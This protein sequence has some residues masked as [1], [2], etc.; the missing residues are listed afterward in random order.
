MTAVPQSAGGNVFTGRGAR[1]RG[2]GGPVVVPRPIREPPSVGGQDYPPRLASTALQGLGHK[3]PHRPPRATCV[4]RPAP[5]SQPEERGA[6]PS[7]VTEVRCAPR[8]CARR[9]GRRSP[10]AGESPAQFALLPPRLAAGAG[11]ALKQGG[12]Q[13]GFSVNHRGRRPG[14]G[15]SR[16]RPRH[17]PPGGPA[18]A[19]SFRTAPS[20]P[21][22]PPLTPRAVTG[23]GSASLPDSARELSFP[24]IIKAGKLKTKKS[25]KASDFSD[26]ANWPTPSELVNTE[27]TFLQCQSVISLGNKKPQSRKEREDK[28]EKRSN[29]ESKE[30]RETKLDGP[31]ENVSE[32]EA[33]SSNQR[34]KANKHKWV[35][36]HLDD[37]RPD[38]QERPGSR[39]SS[40]CQ[41]E[42]NKSS[43]NNRRN[44]TRSWRHE[45]EKRD[46]QDEVSSVRSEG[47]NI[48]GT[49]RGRG[50]SRGRGRGRGRVNPRLNFDY[51][52]GY[53]EHGERTG[54]PFET[55]LN[56]SMMYYYDD[57]TGVQVYPVEEALLK[58]YIKRQIEYY[59]SIENL[60]RDFFLRRKMDEQGFL[61]I[62]LIAG[63]HRVRALTTNLNLILEALKDSTEVEIVDEKMRK[64]IEPEKWPIPGPP[65]RSVPQTDF[66][67]LIDCP[68][69]V[70]GQ[71]FGSHTESA[72]NSPR[73]GS[74]LSPKKN[75]E[76]SNLQAMS[77]DLSA[78]L[79]DLDSEPWIEVK[80]RHRPSPVKLKESPLLSEEASNQLYLPDEQEQE[81]LDFLF[82][83][84]MEQIEGRKNTFTNW[85]D[86]DSD[87]EI[88]DQDLNKILI[89]TQ[90]PPYMRKRPGGDRTGN[91]MS[92]QEVENFKKLNLISKEQFENLTPELPF[93]PNQEVPVAPSQARQAFYFAD[94][95]DEL[96]QKLFDVSEMSSTT[97]ACSLPTAVPESPRIYPSRTPKTPRTPRLQD[98]NKTPRFY[99]VVKEPKAIDVKSPRKRKTRDSTNPPLECH[100]GWVMDSRDHG[101]RTSSVSSSNASPSEGAPLVG[102]YGCTP[103]S[104]PKFQHPSHELLKENGFTQ[105]VYHKYRRRCLSERKHLGIGQSQEMNTLF[106]FWSFFLRDHFNKTMYEEFR[107]LAWEDA[108]ENY[109]YGLECLFRFYSYGL[110]KKFRQ[111]IF[112]DF[113][114]ETKKDYESG[115][116]YGLEKFWAYLK[117]SQS[118]TQSI[119]P[120][121]QEYLCSFKKLEDFRVDP[122]I[123]EEFG[124]KRH[125]STSGEE[126]NRHRP[127]SNSS[128]KS[129]SAAKPT[130]DNQLRVPTNS[131]RRNTSQQSNDNSHQNSAASVSTHGELPEK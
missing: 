123:G 30:S 100:V 102:S 116:L 2:Q 110:E 85:S 7:R 105:Q 87:Y 101:P 26:M 22:P 39:N 47:G 16:E 57:G 59:F 115:Q 38:S 43:H 94:L 34:K 128:T 88:D 36:L 50:R 89:V 63:F 117:Y 119:D 61:P 84:E 96:A 98:Q 121:L 33:Q 51:S 80:K 37:V 104:F 124:R 68:E 56:T 75:T 82:D 106:R 53:Q 103:H 108:K 3:R 74:P 27:K 8:P 58:E 48:R 12:T 5:R 77:R 25:N 112:K 14:E 73:I 18:P 97:M 17:A 55:E 71:A 76:T 4:A 113:Q 42:A 35:P 54:Q 114:E 120:K 60:E 20:T 52:Y 64:K 19:L 49:F 92:R 45:R 72:P 79:P 21:P 91:H 70:P 41:P 29:S 67:Q 11:P 122:P 23:S 31:G 130:P 83:E 125:S 28:V 78:S 1:R 24:Q 62:S 10:G 127:P 118:K 90:T 66:S 15:R 131:P 107:Q 95:T 109:R 129:P 99:P 46:D 40:R 126:S 86:N 9:G 65:P 32:D 93:E 81:E 111:E 69:F 44:D 13:A 6:S